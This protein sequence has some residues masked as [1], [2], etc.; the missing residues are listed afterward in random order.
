MK[1]INEK[2]INRR[3]FLNKTTGI[4]A[5]A[6]AIPCLAASSASGADNSNKKIKVLFMR[7]GYHSP[8]HPEIL[9]KE[10][11]KRTNDFEITFTQNLNDVK[12]ENIKQYDLVANYTT[13]YK[14]SKEQ[15]SGLCDFVFNGGGFVGIHSASDTFKN[16]DRYFEMLGGRFSGHGHEKFTVFIYDSEHPVT[17]GMKDF[18]IEDETYRHKYHR[19]LQ[20]RS[21]TRMNKPGAIERQSMGWVSH[22]GKGRVF[23]TGNGHGEK[24]WKNLQFQRLVT[25]GMYWAAKRKVKDLYV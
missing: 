17:K 3:E 23:Y 20:M 14:L 22:Y 11:L 1:K 9:T 19:N 24:A 5:G 13:G 12:A 7:G 21:L 16:S 25:R 18:E 6:A 15:E 10:L 2:N 8:K 4:M